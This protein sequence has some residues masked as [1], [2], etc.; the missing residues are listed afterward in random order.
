MTFQ[1]LQVMNPTTQSPSS[2]YKDYVPTGTDEAELAN[3]LK[4]NPNF[5]G[6]GDPLN[7]NT[8]DFADAGWEPRD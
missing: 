1:A 2:D 8:G 6:E 4:L 3:W 5:E 7:D